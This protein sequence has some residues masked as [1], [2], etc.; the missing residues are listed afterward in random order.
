VVPEA[1]KPRKINIGNTVPS[2]IAHDPQGAAKA[3]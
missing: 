2:V 3:A 1:L